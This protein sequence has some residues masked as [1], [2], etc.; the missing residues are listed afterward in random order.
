[1]PTLKHFVF[2]IAVAAFLTGSS[3]LLFSQP[4]SDT[5][6]MHFNHLSIKDGLS[7]GMVQCIIQDK[8][9]YMWFASKD[10]LNKYDGYRFTVYRNIP[11]D[12]FSL[13]DNYVTK[14]LE[15]DHGN[16]WIGLSFK[17]ICLF[18]KK[19]E[20]F[21]SVPASLLLQRQNESIQTMSIIDGLLLVSTGI[22]A[23]AY[24]ISKF[25][26][27]DYSTSNLK[28]IRLI[29]NYNTQQPVSSRRLITGAGGKA[30][31]LQDGSLWV[32]FPDSIHICSYKNP[33]NKPEYTS[34]ST[35]EIGASGNVEYGVCEFPGKNK[36][37]VLDKKLNLVD[38]LSHQQ[39]YS[40]V[41]SSRKVNWNPGV[42]DGNN[43]MFFYTDSGDFC[44]DLETK[45]I[46]P[47]L[48]NISSFNTL[49]CSF[50]D[51]SGTLWLGTS[52][53]GIYTYNS[54]K[55]RWLNKSPNS[56]FYAEGKKEELILFDDHRFLKR[57][58]ALTGSIIDYVPLEIEI[59][60]GTR[61]VIYENMILGMHR[62]QD[63]ILWVVCSDSIMSEYL[64]SYNVSKR[65]LQANQI[66][67][68]H[69]VKFK[70]LF[71]DY[72]NR[73]WLLN[74]HDNL[75]SIVQYD[76][77]NSKPIKEYFFPVQSEKN[78]YPFISDWWQD[79]DG[80]FWF[81]TLSGLFSFNEKKNRWRQWKNVPADSTSLSGDLIFSVG[82]DAKEP[83]KYLWIGTNGNGLNRFEF[84]TGKCMRYTEKDG[85]PNNVVYC[86]LNDKAGNLWLSTNKGL[87]CFNSSS[88][89][90]RNFSEE[91]GLPGDEFNRY[92]KLKL[93]SG[94]LLFGGVAGF[95]VFDPGEILKTNPAPAIVLTSLS[96]FNKPVSHTI[97]STIIDAPIGY[98]RSIHLPYEKNMFTLEFAALDFSP[99]PKKQY[100]YKLDGFDQEWIDNGEKNSATYTNLEPGTYTFHVKGTNSEGVW[101]EAGTSIKIIITPPW[102]GTWWFRT[103]A[104][105]I[106]IAAFYALYRFRL[107]Q[108]LKVQKLRNSI[109]RDLHDEI[110]STLSSISLFGESAKMMITPD[111]PLNP[112]LTKI[113][114]STNNMMESMSDIVWAVNTR[115]DQFDNLINRMNAFA[116]QI[117]D[118]KGCQVHFETY[119]E[120][121]SLNLNMEQRKNIYFLFKEIVNN[122][123]KHSGCS[124]LWIT[125]SLSKNLLELRVKDDGKGF[126]MNKAE[127]HGMGG[128]GLMNIRK[129]VTDLK[130]TVSMNSGPGLGT[131]TIVTLK[132]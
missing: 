25:I 128:N 132:M 94:H 74:H 121:I 129:R 36:L 2:L 23:Y 122:S 64:V 42:S 26:P 40:S 80:V 82:P 21:Y 63:D 45:Q 91:D 99:A 75:R 6:R 95:T 84:A 123:A 52:G 11:G 46:R 115:N 5:L 43:R 49:Y 87:S 13:P 110:G 76:K 62:D 103:G 4:G 107:R 120:V 105:I 12:S 53:H 47:V 116:Y 38:I 93:R 24:D 8:E 119:P 113:N 96:V 50:L 86:I 114:T 79:K 68:A 100:E 69:R 56:W 1:M 117:M 98:A 77:V 85:L 51:R 130:A 67:M 104:V 55:E 70:K 58:H 101:N 118:A 89:K 126:L 102:W 109:A 66:S 29:Y 20:K 7:Q 81:G 57:V 19:S 61:K 131:E 37:M 127:S 112:V 73:L 9:G 108:I 18:D 22:N 54:R 34:F 88:G 106:F 15:D 78:D 17:G 60:N 39:F 30:R 28:N 44:I 41:I 33:F 92:E 125:I 124:N 72:D 111:H 90:F 65:L 35:T 14:M 31:W 97:D 48:S 27:G 71:I 16:F 32:F 3:G 83:D 59:P 10:G